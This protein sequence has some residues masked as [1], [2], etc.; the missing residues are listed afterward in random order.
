MVLTCVGN[1]AEMKKEKEALD[2]E[3]DEDS[4]N[5]SLC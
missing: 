1:Q 5:V 3:D 2:S 4:S